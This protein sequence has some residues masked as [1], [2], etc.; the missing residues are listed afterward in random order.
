MDG[1][2]P[3]KLGNT[4]T[5]WELIMAKNLLSIVPTLTKEEWYVVYSSLTIWSMKNVSTKYRNLDRHLLG[6]VD[7]DLVLAGLKR[8]M[9]H[10]PVE[11]AERSLLRKLMEE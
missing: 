10:D 7:R 5:I 6:L 11:A 8:R 2:Q 9:K 3:A 4:L 1:V